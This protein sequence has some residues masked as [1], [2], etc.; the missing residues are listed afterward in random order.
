MASNIEDLTVCVVCYQ[1]FTNPK[2]LTCDHVFCEACVSQ[3]K[4][5]N[6]ICCPR[7]RDVSSVYSIVPD[8][9]MATF[10]DA[11]EEQE[12]KLLE[13]PADTKDIVAGSIDGSI[14]NMYK[15]NLCE[16]H[17]VVGRCD[18]CAVWLCNTC[19]LAHAKSSYTVSHTVSPMKNYSKALQ[20]KLMKVDADIREKMRPFEEVVSQCESGMDRVAQVL[21]KA[22]CE[23][24]A[25]RAKC[26]EAFNTMENNIHKQLSMTN[27]KFEHVRYQACEA[28]QQ[29][30]LYHDEIARVDNSKNNTMLVMEGGQLIKKVESYVASVAN[31]EPVD[32]CIPNISIEV[33]QQ[34][35]DG[36]TLRFIYDG[37]SVDSSVNLLNTT[38]MF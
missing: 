28:I 26:L 29:L 2:R 24:R 33:N 14:P 5:G 27:H 23:C 25:F 11:L 16:T 36:Y 35:R 37:E 38:K 30:E 6:V 15:C 18:V 20:S 4:R 13:P 8:H 31:P 7:C 1:P 9:R 22:L 32:V 10:M 21:D 34:M 17:V 3:I 19:R 12:A